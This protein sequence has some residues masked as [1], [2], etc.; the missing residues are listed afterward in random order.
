MDFMVIVK[1]FRNILFIILVAYV[2]VVFSKNLQVYLLHKIYLLGEG[3]DDGAAQVFIENKADYKPIILDMLNSKKMSSYEVDVTFVFADLLKDDADI[4]NKLKDISENYPQK[5]V[6]C[7]WH[8]VL[9][10]R[11]EETRILQKQPGDGTNTYGAYK[12]VDHGTKCE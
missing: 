6:R 11:F 12:L 3:L 5:D 8:D 2:A 1:Y 10:G 4:Y 7:F 9:N